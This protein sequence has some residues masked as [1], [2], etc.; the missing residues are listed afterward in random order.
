[1][2]FNGSNSCLI[3]MQTLLL[4]ANASIGGQGKEAEGEKGEESAMQSSR[5][6]EA[7]AF[8]KMGKRQS[9]RS[10]AGGAAGEPKRT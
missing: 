2:H 7:F 4:K 9:F 10:G 8:P 1:M 3:V 5:L 6:Q